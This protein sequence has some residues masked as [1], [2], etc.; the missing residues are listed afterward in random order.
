MSSRLRYVI[1]ASV[2]I[3]FLVKE[4]YSLFVKQFLH[5][6]H[7]EGGF[8][9]YVPDL[10][11]IECANILWKKVRRG[12]VDILTVEANLSVLLAMELSTTPL[13]ELAVRAVCLACDHGISAYDASYLALSERLGVP[14]L[15][16]D[17]RLANA[18]ANS[19]HQVIT[20]ASLSS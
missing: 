3:K 2:L 7:A 15:T 14:L 8:N 20:L 19:T 4:E 9:I 5:E 13:S 6:L 1:D 18:L 17:N 11:Y 10:L 12:E 16:A